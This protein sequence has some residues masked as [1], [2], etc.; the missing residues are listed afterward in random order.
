MVGSIHHQCLDPPGRKVGGRDK[1]TP[2][3]AA[4]DPWFRYSTFRERLRQKIWPVSCDTKP[5]KWPGIGCV[6]L[7]RASTTSYSLAQFSFGG[8]QGYC[9]VSVCLN[10]YSRLFY[11]QLL[12]YSLYCV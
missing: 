10:S 6:F 5:N 8:M 1:S 9:M 3:N 11:I 2:C 12:S 4:S 7:Q